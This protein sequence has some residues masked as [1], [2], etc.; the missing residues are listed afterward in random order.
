MQDVNVLVAFWSR[1]G[2]TEKLGLAAALGAVQARANIR[3]RWLR[4]DVDARALAEFPGWRENRER[5]D[6]EYVPPREADL[7]WADALIMG[8]PARAK[9][10]G[11]EFQ[12]CFELLRA[13]QVKGQ[14]RCR[15]GAAVISGAGP[16]DSALPTIYASL[17][18]VGMILVPPPFGSV[19]DAVQAARAHG[20]RVTEVAR[21]LK[22]L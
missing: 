8:A 22:G 14:L 10:P 16:N 9:L 11:P 15:V 7:A 3:L 1:T 19:A 13:V 18:V 17:A 2:A 20:R 5:M 4:E 21:A 6:R 12:S